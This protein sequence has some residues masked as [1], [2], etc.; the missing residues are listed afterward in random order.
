MKA[1]K[2]SHFDITHNYKKGD[3]ALFEGLEIEFMPIIN[4]DFCI[5]KRMEAYKEG[6]LSQYVG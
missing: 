1:D 6:S 2:L 3:K 5:G 4:A